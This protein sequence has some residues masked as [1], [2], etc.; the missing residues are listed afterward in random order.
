MGKFD[1][2][3]DPLSGV[4]I[5]A[6]VSHLTARCLLPSEIDS[7]VSDLKLELDQVAERAKAAIWGIKDLPDLPEGL[8]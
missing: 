5:I 1:I 2:D 4:A 7:Y 8:N 3:A 6:T